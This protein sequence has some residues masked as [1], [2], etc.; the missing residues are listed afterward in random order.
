MTTCLLCIQRSTYYFT[1][2]NKFILF[3]FF[4][5]RSESEFDSS[6]ALG[7]S[8][9]PSLQSKLSSAIN[10]STK[11]DESN[12]SQDLIVSVANSSKTRDAW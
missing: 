3:I 9:T 10:L 7:G 11:S 12:S 5:F 6:C 4:Y 2:K 1:I 8:S